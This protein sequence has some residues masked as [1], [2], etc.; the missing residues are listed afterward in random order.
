MMRTI[1]EWHERAGR[2]SLAARELEHL[3]DFVFNAKGQAYRGADLDRIR[4][5]HMTLGAYYAGRRAW[6]GTPRGA[7]FQLERMRAATQSLRA[8]GRDVGDPPELL[9]L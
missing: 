1:G 6:A 7:I 9:E 3:L 4:Q 2:D 5:F 8:A